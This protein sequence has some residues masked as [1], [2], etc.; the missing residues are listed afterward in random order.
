MVFSTDGREAKADERRFVPQILLWASGMSSS[1]TTREKVPPPLLNATRRRV[2]RVFGV[3]E[4]VLNK[5]GV[6]WLNGG[7]KVTVAAISL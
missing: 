2:Q 1:F 6:E 5:P 4:N 3:L 7:D